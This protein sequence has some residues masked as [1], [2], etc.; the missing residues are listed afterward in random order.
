MPSVASGDPDDPAG[1]DD[2]AQVVRHG[3]VA[4]EVRC[5]DPREHDAALLRDLRAAGHRSGYAGAAVLCRRLDDVRH[6]LALLRRAGVPVQSLEDYDGSGTDAVKVGTYKRAKGLEL[7][8]VFLPRLA[9]R[10]EPAGTAQA[11]EAERRDRELHVAAT[12]ARDELWLGF[13][14]R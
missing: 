9:P 10:A 8:V 12:R 2:P 7:P 4:V 11:E 6:Y 14:S 13:L 1:P 3:P 5:T